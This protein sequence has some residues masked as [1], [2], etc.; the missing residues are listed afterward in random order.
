MEAVLLDYHAHVLAL[1]ATRTALA[2]AT[3][4]DATLVA[5]RSAIQAD[6]AVAA[7]YA[8]LGAF[9]NHLFAHAASDGRELALLRRADALWQ[10]GLALYDQLGSVRAR[11]ENALASPAAPGAADQFNSAANDVQLF[12]QGASAMLAD[13]VAL[14]D[15]ASTL[16]F[17]S[18]HPRQLDQPSGAWDWAN[19][20]LGRRTDAFVRNLTRAAQGTATRAFAFGAL[21]SYGASAAGSAYLGVVVGGPRRSHRFRD[22]LARNA[23]GSWLA[24]TYATTSPA[25]LAQALT[26]GSPLAPT[27]PARVVEQLTGALG[28]TFD[29]TRTAPLPD[30][31]LGY[32]RLLE[33]LSLLGGFARPPVPAPPQGVWQSKL[34]GDPSIPPPSLRPKDTG[35]SGDPGGGVSLGNNSPG[36][37]QP[38]QSDN[39][40]ASTICG[41]IMA[42]LIIIDVIQ[43]F[44]QCIVQWAK[45]E[46]CT[47][48]DNMLLKKL[49]EKD[50]PDPRD[51]PTTSEAAVSTADLVAM[52]SSDQVTQLVGCLF[53]IH[54]QVWEGLDRAYHFLAF[55]GLIYPGALIDV[56]VYRQFTTVPGAVPPLPRRPVTDPVNRYHLYPDSPLEQPAAPGA[57]FAAGARPDAFLPLA[58]DRIALPL[59]QQ[60]ARGE[61]D[62]ANLDLD[63]D[64]SFLHPC[65]A[66]AGSINDDPVGV[67]VL[68]YTDQ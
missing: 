63:A 44:V 61:S 40:A 10:R 23:I 67:V 17:L 50:P 28:A 16:S 12:S 3:F 52:S 60:M 4:T 25:K 1:A 7:D 21:V 32:R 27:L 41:I 30:L 24:R 22:R 53:D 29:L 19:L 49:W 39:S 9:V 26:F 33:H 46:T 11:L 55:H 8:Q 14:R 51:P 66:T 68:A 35:V 38:G 57:P 31:Q 42:I 56:P 37:A 36:G 20:L 59:W 34:Y 15:D 2:S 5:A 48:W 6:L 45:K 58:A 65:W 54:T 47:F 43:A 13:V 62:S 18:P 64:R